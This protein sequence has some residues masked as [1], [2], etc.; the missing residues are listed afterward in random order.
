MYFV[1]ILL[2]R[3]PSQ[4]YTEERERE[5]TMY[6][7]MDENYFIYSIPFLM[8]T[9]RNTI[10]DL[11]AL[12]LYARL[13]RSIR[14]TSHKCWVSSYEWRNGDC[15]R[16]SHMFEPEAILLAAPLFGKRGDEDESHLMNEFTSS[17]RRICFCISI[18]LQ[19]S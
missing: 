10:Y 5:G 2:R 4:Q 18:S 14:R 12:R 7:A 16:F 8:S 15:V 1:S 19:M 3:L 17:L 13:L 9:E 6:D 11:R